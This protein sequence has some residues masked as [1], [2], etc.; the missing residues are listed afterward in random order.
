VP[1]ARRGGV[2]IDALE[3][4]LDVRGRVPWKRVRPHPQNEVR[5]R[6][7]G[8]VDYVNASRRSRGEQRADR[9]LTAVL[10]AR[11]DA[12]GGPRL[13]FDLLSAW[14]RLVLA[15]DDASFRRAAAFAKQ[16]RERYGLRRDTVAVFD[17]CLAGAQDDPLPLAA[18]AARA[19]LDVCFF[20]PFADGNAR[21][22]LVVLDF[23]LALADVRLEQVAPVVVPRRADDA[24]G[25]LALA[26]LI[27]M[28]I[29]STG[30]QRHRVPSPPAPA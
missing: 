17:H 28:L 6:R 15:T 2:E 16:G 20:H 21:A 24:E 5:G 19:Y 29:I 23:L 14:Q 3:T 10:Q 1:P 12:A 9:L 11:A 8:V 27:A 13:G 7:D 30:R 22:A 18:R 25:A 4:W 26:D